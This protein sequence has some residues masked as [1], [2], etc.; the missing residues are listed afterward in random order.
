MRETNEEEQREAYMIEK[1][2]VRKL[3]ET[4]M[5]TRD[6]MWITSTVDISH[7][8]GL[9]KKRREARERQKGNSG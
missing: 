3:M 2:R 8:N 4:A 9:E 7:G 6:K 5:K 1:E